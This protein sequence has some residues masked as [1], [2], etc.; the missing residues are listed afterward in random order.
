MD[1]ILYALAAPSFFMAESQGRIV[2]C[3]S[4]SVLGVSHEKPLRVTVVKESMNEHELPLKSLR[5][6]YRVT[7]KL[8]YLIEDLLEAHTL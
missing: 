2:C 8:S 1:R 7:K 6:L 3:H 4:L 5:L